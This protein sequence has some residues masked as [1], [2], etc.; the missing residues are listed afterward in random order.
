MTENLAWFDIEAIRTR[1]AKADCFMGTRGNQR[2]DPGR[3]SD[4]VAGFCLAA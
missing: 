3:T 1:P 4:S 2:P